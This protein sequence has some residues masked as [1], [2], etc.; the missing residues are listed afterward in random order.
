MDTQAT[1]DEALARL[2]AE[3][4]ARFEAALT[5]Q[6][7]RD[8]NAKLLGKKGELTA[9]LKDMGKIPGDARKAVGE[10]VNRLKQDVEA[11]FEKRLG[12]VARAKR[13]AE[14]NARPFD[15]TLP[16]RE[17]AQLGHKHPISLV[18]EELVEIFRGMGFAVHDGPDV[19][20]EE[21]N[22]GKLG[23]PPD[24]PATDMQDTFW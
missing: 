1:I 17:L 13:D 8:E 24:H 19:E 5:E 23:Y 22:F 15:L 4:P 7:L 9:I 21:N 3:F 12:A 11:A 10:K 18:R 6:A 16:G 20:H 14:L 2:R